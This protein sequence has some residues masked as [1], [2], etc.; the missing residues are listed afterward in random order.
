M[1][2]I[3]VITSAEVASIDASPTK[4]KRRYERHSSDGGAD[5]NRPYEWVVVGGMAVREPMAGSS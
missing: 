4:E 3:A 5:A 1:C 2:G